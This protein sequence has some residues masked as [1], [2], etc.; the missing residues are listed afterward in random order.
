MELHFS[1]AAREKIGAFLDEEESPD[2]AVRVRVTRPS[3]VAP[4]YEMILVGREER[5]PDDE[6]LE[7]AGYPLFVDPESVR[8]LDGTHVEWVESLQGSGFRFENPNLRPSSAREL[9]GS[10]AERVQRVLEERINPGVARH[11][12]RVSLVEIKD[13]V[14]FLRMGGG[15]QG[16]GLASVTLSQGVKQILLEEVPELRAVEDVT[17]HSA[18]T[19]PYF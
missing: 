4:E 9:S 18:G 14:A 2:L 11:G 16:C 5:Q 3:P 17:D 12:G 1:D 8:L 10:L 19:R 7:V 6:E 13:D 15:C